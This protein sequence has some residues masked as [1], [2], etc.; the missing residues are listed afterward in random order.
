MKF[1]GWTDIIHFISPNHST[2][3][4]NQF[5]IKKKDLRPYP[6]YYLLIDY[7]TMLRSICSLLLFVTVT[8]YAMAPSSESTQACGTSGDAGGKKY[9]L[10]CSEGDPT[11]TSLSFGDDITCTCAGGVPCAVLI[12]GKKST[13]EDYAKL[14]S[15]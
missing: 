8:A 7:R 4:T 12:D 6:R 10:Y 5:L 11:A 14:T 9:C 15:L 3:G 1:L 2:A 13:L